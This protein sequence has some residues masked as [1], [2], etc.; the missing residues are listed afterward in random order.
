MTASYSAYL[1]A[2]T[3]LREQAG[4][5]SAD[6]ARAEASG[7]TEL[8]AAAHRAR[9]AEESGRD[10]SRRLRTVSDQLARLARDVQF[11]LE[12]IPS[13]QRPPGSLPDTER[14][15]ADLQRE[16]T[17]IEGNCDWV[18]RNRSA[19]LRAPA[20]APA[21]TLPTS[22]PAVVAAPAGAAPPTK[23]VWQNPIVW[24]A[25]AAA[26]ILVLVVLLVLK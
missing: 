19:A 16:L 22:A 23:P 25:V 5:L 21:P 24:I 20:S 17:A 4:R 13:A 8:D 15:L 9:N 6:L 14:L 10:A 26:V 12:P 1:A 2:V 11:D 18:R 7:Q 3:T